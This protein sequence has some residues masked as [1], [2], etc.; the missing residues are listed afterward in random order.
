MVIVTVVAGLC[1][2]TCVLAIVWFIYRRKIR[3]R[4][5]KGGADADI[6]M[7]DE[8]ERG[9]GPNVSHTVILVEPQMTSP[10]K[11][12]SGREGSEGSVKAY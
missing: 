9:T 1:L 6:S 2:L 7:D 8:F 3:S 10:M 5:G 4:Q 12:S 11:G